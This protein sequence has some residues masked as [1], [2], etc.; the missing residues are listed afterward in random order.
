MI[1]EF[2]IFENIQKP[3]IDENTIR[4]TGERGWYID[5]YFEKVK[6]GKK[7]I[8][9]DNKWDIKIPDWY[10]LTVYEPLN[11]IKNWAKKYDP[12]CE[13]YYILKHDTNKYNL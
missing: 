10:Q 11:I 4:V 3:K 13:V 8:Y 1:T 7:F 5:F 12:N 2:K 9:I 6:D